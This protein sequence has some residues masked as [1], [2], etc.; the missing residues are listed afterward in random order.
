MRWM[1]QQMLLVGLRLAA[2]QHARLAASCSREA[3]GYVVPKEGGR[4]SIAPISH[5]QLSRDEAQSG[6]SALGMHR[7]LFT[8]RKGA[9]V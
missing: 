4:R 9:F 2:N 8:W 5:P 1:G 6:S 7:N 3:P